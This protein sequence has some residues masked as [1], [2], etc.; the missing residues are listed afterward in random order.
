MRIRWPPAAP[1][2]SESPARGFSCESLG[3]TADMLAKPLAALM[4]GFVPINLPADNVFP[5]GMMSRG[6]RLIGI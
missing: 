6:D 3:Y 5:T 1:A 4:P 2:R